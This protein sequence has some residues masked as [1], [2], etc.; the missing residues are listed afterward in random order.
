MSAPVVFVVSLVVCFVLCLSL[1]VVGF[2]AFSGQ[3]TGLAIQSSV[4]WILDL[5]LLVSRQIL[6]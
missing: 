3:R 4:L 1:S 2:Q 5:E 6:E